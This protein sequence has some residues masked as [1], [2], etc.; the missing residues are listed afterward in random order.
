MD[1][2]DELL[3]PQI[4]RFVTEHPWAILPEKLAVIEEV[5]ALRAQGIRFTA[6]EIQARIGAAAVRPAARASGSVAVL[7]L[8]G[9]VTQR[10]GLMTQMSG[11]TS[12]EAFS[13]ALRQA[14]ADD[15]VGSILIEVDSPGGNVA[16]VPEL[17]DEIYRLRGQKPI[18]ASANTL[19]ASAAYW[20]ASSA[21]EIVVTPSADIGSIG[22]I[23]MHQDRSQ[24]MEQLGV[25]TTFITAGR[26]KAEGNPFEPLSEEARAFIQSRV[27]GYYDMFVRAVAR[28]RGVSVSTVK[29]DFGE[30][31]VVGPK[32]AVRAGMADR[33][34]T[35]RDTI[36]RLSGSRGSRGAGTRVGAET[37]VE[38]VMSGGDGADLDRRRRRLRL[39]A[40]L[41]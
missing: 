5:L 40:N 8:F 7:P 27:D 26:F 17:A 21:D 35:L 1:A 29:S 16:G 15:S 18:V 4:R 37:P 3:Y 38:E 6:E 23:A 31:R 36:A 11:G 12:T 33:I 39:D 41:H 28:N 14:L 25:R 2:P 30:G 22:V 24:A 13:A 10:A 19:M 20:I 32:E 34:E 9:V